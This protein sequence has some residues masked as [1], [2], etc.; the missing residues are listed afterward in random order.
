MD[1][2]AEYLYVV[3]SAT[4]YR[5]G[6]LIRFVTREPYNHVAISTEA[7]LT[8]M[9]SFAR[10]FYRTPFYGGFVTEEPYRYHHRSSVAQI[11]VCRVPLS[12]EQ[13]AHLSQRLRYME[14]NTQKYIYNHLSALAAPIHRR[15][16]VSEAFT[17]AEFVVNVL[18]DLGLPFDRHRFYTIG[19]IYQ[20]LESSRIYTG[21][22]PLPTPMPDGSVF[23]ERH[24][25][26]HP[27][28]ES[29]RSIFALLQRKV[30]A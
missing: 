23:F 24:P 16:P 6:K 18:S 22:F 15:I 29:A 14:E 10:R 1:E 3:F 13:S 9:Y 21:E 28:Y 5:M 17:C 26:P 8:R 25:L 20:V 2:E 30:H 12:P 7:S 4:P 11:C 27:L 19:Q